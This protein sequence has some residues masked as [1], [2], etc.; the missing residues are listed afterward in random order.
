MSNKKILF[1][2]ARGF[3]LIELVVVVAI[4]G[5]LAGLL[6]PGLMKKSIDA[7]VSTAKNN[8]QLVFNSTQQWLQTEIL[9]N[10]RTYPSGTFIQGDGSDVAIGVDNEL[11]ANNNFY[12]TW[13]VTIDSD[14]GI[15]ALW[16]K[17]ESTDLS[18]RDQM[19]NQEMKD[20]K[21]KIGCYPSA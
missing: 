12:G 20:E 10:E 18:S 6:V 9:E 3:T 11:K 1:R 14:G 4:I 15:Y 17:D 16:A 13:S 19:T 21:G 5:I 8:A 7:K 2:K